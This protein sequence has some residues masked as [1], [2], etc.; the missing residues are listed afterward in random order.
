MFHFY[1]TFFK[2]CIKSFIYNLFYIQATIMPNYVM[3]YKKDKT[4]SHD[5]ALPK[6]THIMNRDLFGKERPEKSPE[7]GL[8]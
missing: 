3:V 2:K 5:I 7:K 1:S 6:Q 8:R 4:I